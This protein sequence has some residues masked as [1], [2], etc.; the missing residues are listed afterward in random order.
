MF[1]NVCM[2]TFTKGTCIVSYYSTYVGNEHTP[3]YWLMSDSLVFHN[4][5]LLL[6]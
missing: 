1:L 2:A 5:T 3:L 4:S 6:T